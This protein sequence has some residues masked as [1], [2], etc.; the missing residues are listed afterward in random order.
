[1]S[2]PIDCNN[3]FLISVSGR[4]Y[5]CGKCSFNQRLVVPDP[6]GFINT[7]TI[8]ALAAVHGWQIVSIGQGEHRFYCGCQRCKQ[9]QEEHERKA[10]KR[11]DEERVES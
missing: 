7:D 6:P 8:K 1:M 2:K 9:D 5:C 3:P 11:R 4:C 10:Q